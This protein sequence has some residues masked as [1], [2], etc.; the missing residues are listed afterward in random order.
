VTG[1]ILDESNKK[2]TMII[3]DE[4]LGTAIGRRGVNPRLAS[5]LTGYTIEI[6][7]LTS[8]TAE[9]LKF[10]TV[11]SLRNQDDLKKQRE[12]LPNPTQGQTQSG[13]I[14]RV[15][16]ESFTMEDVMA[17][18][19]DE[20]T[21]DKT[22]QDQPVVPSL[23]SV[24]SDAK[25]VE[26]VPVVKKPIPVA[27]PPKVTMV[28]TTKTLEELEKELDQQKARTP[29]PDRFDKKKKP[30]KRRERDDKPQVP[31]IGASPESLN[32]ANF[33]KIYDDETPEAAAPVTT[34]VVEETE[35]E[36]EDFDEYYEEEK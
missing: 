13:S 12:A 28:R 36:L 31:S 22:G 23:T 9:G 30:F 2:A 33:M 18:K 11:D 24:S 20:S 27:E 25:P 29:K 1:I 15:H 35:V 19:R 34:P 32:P 8:T 5:K 21:F 26:T 14:N 10:A 4:N 7:D 17:P 16:D 3:A 6:K